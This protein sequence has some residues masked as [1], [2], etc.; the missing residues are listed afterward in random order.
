MSKYKKYS[1]KKIE[2]LVEEHKFEVLKL[3]QNATLF[4][5]TKGLGL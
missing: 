2:K 4:W 5:Q 3:Q 1:N